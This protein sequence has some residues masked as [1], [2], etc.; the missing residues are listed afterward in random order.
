MNLQIAR[1]LVLCA[2]FTIAACGGDDTEPSAEGRSF[3]LENRAGQQ[4]EP[5][6][7]GLPATVGVPVGERLVIKA[8]VPVRWRIEYAG[9]SSIG[10]GRTL[11]FSTVTVNEL[12]SSNPSTVWSADLAGTTSPGGNVTFN[13]VAETSPETVFQVNVR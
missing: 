8:T 3:V 11:Q 10:F 13:V 12:T 4:S 2:L 9:Q 1:G 5:H 6:T 7:Y